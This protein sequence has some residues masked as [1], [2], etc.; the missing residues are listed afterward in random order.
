MLLTTEFQ[1]RFSFGQQ[2][3]RTLAR[4][5]Y[6][7]FTKRYDWTQNVRAISIRA[8]ALAPVAEAVQIDLFSDPVRLERQG[9]IDRTVDDIRLKYGEFSL[10][11]AVLLQ[12]NK[13]PFAKPKSMFPERGFCRKA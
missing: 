3:A 2:S 1:C 5:A 8:I 9:K 4:Q 7:M 12:D 10:R 13:M 6:K 11:H